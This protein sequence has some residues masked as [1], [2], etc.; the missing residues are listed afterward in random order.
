M[1]WLCNQECMNEWACI[2]FCNQTR[3]LGW[4]GEGGGIF[5]SLWF[6]PSCF[7]FFFGLS[8]QSRTVMIIPLPIRGATGA[9]G[10]GGGQVP[11]H[12][13]RFCFFLV[14]SSAVGH[15]H[16][17]TPTP[18]LNF[19]DKLLKSDKGWRNTQRDILPGLCVCVCGGGGGGPM[20]F[21]FGCFCC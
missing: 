13:F 6:L 20:I 2:I 9:G 14:V 1:T 5:P 12:D 4:Q 17:S 19:L 18:L 15:G 21:V 7:L 8:A 10:G 3:R 16:D 11:P